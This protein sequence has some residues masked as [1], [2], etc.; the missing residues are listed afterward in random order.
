MTKVTEQ[1]I[2]KV[3]TNDELKTINCSGAMCGAF[4]GCI[5][6]K[7]VKELSRTN[8]DGFIDYLAE[9]KHY[10]YQSY[11]LKIKSDKIKEL[12]RIFEI[13]E[14]AKKMNNKV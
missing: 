9:K 11:K 12:N 2:S 6:W 14:Y 13:E 1:N 10:C 5:L 3:A 8:G 7:K 4:K